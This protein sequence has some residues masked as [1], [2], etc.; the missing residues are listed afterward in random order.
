VPL[1][2]Q[3][4]I[5][6]A[7]REL[8][9]RRLVVGS[10]GNVSARSATG[11][12][13]TPTRRR[14]GG[15]RARDVVAVDRHG[16]SPR[17]GRVPSRESALHA[18]IYAARADVGAIV[19]HHGPFSTACSF[20]AGEL[21]PRLEEAEYFAIGP[22]RTAAPAP[23]GAPELAAACVAALGDS[24]AVLLAGHGLVATGPDVGAALDVSLAVEH[25]AHVAW[26]LRA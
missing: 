18:A 19:H 15:L 24:Q 4:E 26:L 9:A 6:R 7:A 17:P 8:S 14:Y 3:R 23:A 21:Q 12:L 2:R 22:V 25:E 10:T 1:A 13:I 16:V 5:V 11:F 20:G